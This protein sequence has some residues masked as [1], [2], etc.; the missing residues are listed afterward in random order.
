MPGHE[1]DTKEP[2]GNRIDAPL[3]DLL[4]ALGDVREAVSRAEKAAREAERASEE[5]SAPTGPETAPRWTWRS[6]L[7]ACPPETRLGIRELV[8][9]LGVSKSWVYS[10][11]K[12]EADDPLPH[13]KLGGALLFVA[14]ELRHWIRTHEEAPVEGP[15]WSPAEGGLGLVDPEAA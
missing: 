15:S 6:R 4:E 8:E 5:G 13:R 2:S 12:S 11:T 1:Q 7:W 14:G 10:R 3:S 9:A